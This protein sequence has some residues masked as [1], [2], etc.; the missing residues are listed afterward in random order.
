MSG[1]K[2]SGVCRRLLCAALTVLMLFEASGSA[3]AYLVTG[4]GSAPTSVVYTDTNGNTQPVDESWEETFPY[5]AFAFETSGLA[6]SE[7]ESGVIKVYRL[8]GTTGRRRPISPMS[9]FCSRMRTAGRCTTMPSAPTMWPSK[10][11]SRCPA[12]GMTRWGCRPCRRRGTRRCGRCRRAGVFPPAVRDGAELSVADPL[13]RR[14]EGHP[15][16]RRGGGPGGRGVHRQRQLR[17]PL[18]LHAGRG[19]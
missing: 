12:P 2:G 9:P 5:G 19:E 10:W 3:L 16:R 6:L 1:K 7:G 11:R 18:H 17:L 14:V 4:E 8:G 15:G 13:R